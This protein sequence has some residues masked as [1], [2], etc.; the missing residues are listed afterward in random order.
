ME[1]AK[2]FGNAVTFYLGVPF[3][4]AFGVA[5]ALVTGFVGFVFALVVLIFA[6]GCSAQVGKPIVSFVSIDVVNLF[7]RER[8]GHVKPRQS[9]FVKLFVVNF[10]G[11]I[12]GTVVSPGYAA[13]QTFV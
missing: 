6:A 3:F 7:W 1:T 11:S 10:N 2:E 9:V 4:A 13:K 12:A 5:N 8:A